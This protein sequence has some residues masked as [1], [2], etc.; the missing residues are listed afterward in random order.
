[1]GDRLPHRELTEAE[2]GEHLAVITSNVAALR[3]YLVDAALLDRTADGSS[4]RRR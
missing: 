4:Y 2:L 1:M 3:R